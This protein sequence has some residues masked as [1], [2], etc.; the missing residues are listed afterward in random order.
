[1]SSID[2][3]RLWSWLFAIPNP[4][5]SLRRSLGGLHP[6]VSKKNMLADMRAVNKRQGMDRLVDTWRIAWNDENGCPYH[7]LLPAFGITRAEVVLWWFGE[8]PKCKL[9]KILLEKTPLRM[10][11]SGCWHVGK[12]EDAV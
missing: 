7:R 2:R 12:E 8:Y 4:V 11:I 1:M 3:A 6:P 9:V 5:T 10:A